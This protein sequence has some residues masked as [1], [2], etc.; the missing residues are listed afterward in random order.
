MDAVDISIEGLE[1]T[2]LVFRYVPL[3]KAYMKGKTSQIG[4]V[5]EEQL[6]SSRG[7]IKDQVPGILLRQEKF[8]V[9]RRSVTKTEF[10]VQ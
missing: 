10:L 6:L 8:S 5:K 7:Q 1:Y 9:N 4:M 3:K 2:N